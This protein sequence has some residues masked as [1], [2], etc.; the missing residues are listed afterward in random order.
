[1]SGESA[2]HAA[3][4]AC[5]RAPDASTR[6]LWTGRDDGALPEVARWH[7]SVRMVDLSR[8]IDFC[9]E[10]TI[11]VIGYASDLGVARN[12]G[13]VGASEGPRAIRGRLA[14]LPCVKGVQLLDCGDVVGDAAAGHSVADT[15]EALAA[16]VERLVRAGALPFVVGGGHDQAFGHFLG[17]A[18]GRGTAPACVNFDAHL[19]LRPIPADG[20]NSGT[21]YTQAWEWCRARNAAFRYI[22]LGIQRPGNTPLLYRRAEEA[23]VTVVDAD[24]FALDM[25]DVVMDAVNDAVDEAELCISIDLDVF[26]AAFA[27]GVSAPTAMGIA[28][29]AAF[30]RV[31][32]G[33]LESGRVRG[34]EIA[35]LCPALDIDGRTARLAAALAFEVALALEEREEGDESDESVELP[36]PDDDSPGV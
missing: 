33:L 34:V 22:A 13:R 21:P 27:P 11:A 25:L 15:Q 32:R 9:I 30:R 36:A 26:A 3:F 4:R 35:E 17:V 8:D 1:V 24:G 7:Q 29:D 18:R 31:L 10:P 2:E 20:P 5:Y 16:A 6:A 23:G 14:P 12:L 28:P 19:D